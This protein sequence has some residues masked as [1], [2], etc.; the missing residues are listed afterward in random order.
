MYDNF[1]MNDKLL[2]LDRSGRTGAKKRGKLERSLGSYLD[3]SPI[4]DERKVLITD[5][6]EVADG[7]QHIQVPSSQHRR[8]QSWLQTCH[9]TQS[10][11]N[12]RSKEKTI[13]DPN[14][15]MDTVLQELVFNPNGAASYYWMAT[16]TAAVMYNYWVVILRIAFLE[17]RQTSLN[18]QCFF[19]LDIISD[20]IYLLDIGVQLRTAYL[21]NGILVFDTVKMSN[22]YRQKR[23]FIKDVIAVAP[24]G[25][26]FNIFAVVVYVTIGSTQVGE[27]DIFG[28][29]MRLPRL[30]KYHTMM[31]FFDV[32]DSRTSSPYRVRAFK[33]TLYL[34]VV[35]HWIACF[36]HVVSEYEGF[37]SNNWVYP[38]DEED[39]VFARKY[40]R[41]MYWSMMT[42]TT[43]GET[44]TPETDM[45]Y[46]F[47]GF[48]FLVGVFVF[49][50]VVGNVGDVISNMNA[51]RQEFQGRMDSVKFYM[52]HRKVPQHLQDRVKQWADY[53]WTR[54]QA[55][56]QSNQLDLL[57]ERLQAEI[58]I[59]IHLDILKKVKIFEECEEGLLR[60]L[61]LKLKSQI[62]SPGDYICRTGEIGR[63]M[64]IINHGRVEILVTNGETGDSMV[65]ATLS[66][67]N[68]FGEISLLKLDY[69]QN[70][71]TAD[72][73][74]VGY[75]ELLCLSRKDLITA[76]V[77][78]PEA[79]KVLEQQARERIKK[80][81]EARRTCSSDSLP[82]TNSP[83]HS[84]SS[85]EKPI[86][87]NTIYPT[88]PPK[89]EKLK[90]VIQSD[91]FRKLM[92]NKG[93]EVSEL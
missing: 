87:G 42:L 17:M 64:Y 93:K 26:L 89:S 24:L 28:P 85:D 39:Q 40:I 21:E 60:E 67:G 19:Y 57:P 44:N 91:E 47:T 49:A 7:Q 66:E 82:T 30:L 83:N 3:I 20:I 80:N 73:Q 15:K 65:V 53:S 68:Y 18:Q 55:L 88:I 81:R 9:S 75:S 38:A 70:K 16:V 54:T 50:A 43:I 45:E 74:S 48:T 72:V 23:R 79:K 33:L 86:Y 10:K 14:G 8:R 5:S 2:I 76:L 69:G 4:D 27:T 59:H 92:L 32:T 90:E 58:A 36:Y 77:E 6:K 71:R 84:I 62:Y 56:N 78:Y 37:G 34:W 46:V 25:T 11:D 12:Y 61:V 29:I 51:A 41:C 31:K 22:H 52:N 63:E 1:K 35:I 13:E